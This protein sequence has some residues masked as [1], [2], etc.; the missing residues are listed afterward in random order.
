MILVDLA[1]LRSAPELASLE[2]LSH[3]LEVTLVAIRAA[4]PCLDSGRVC[5][6]SLAPCHLAA[7][8]HDCI[9]ELDNAII[10]YRADVEHSLCSEVERTWH[11]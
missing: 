1:L 8:L 10:N 4:H 2:I 7:K 11:F 5:H 6:G 3:V 9:D